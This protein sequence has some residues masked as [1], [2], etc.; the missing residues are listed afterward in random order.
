MSAPITR[1]PKT[2][3]LLTRFVTEADVGLR[4]VDDLLMAS[5]RDPMSRAALG[6]MRQVFHEL[7]HVSRRVEADDVLRLSRVTET[8]LE[9]TSAGVVVADQAVVDALFEASLVMRELL[10]EV[11]SA[12]VE[13]RTFVSAKALDTT[14]SKLMLAGES[15]EE[16]SR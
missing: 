6:E 13:S 4:R 8:L 16:D 15:D 1:D 12:A 7:S 10:E 11:W 14:V 5:T 3:D 2:L 9:A